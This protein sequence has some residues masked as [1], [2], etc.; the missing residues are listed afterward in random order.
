M[1]A[2]LP[3]IERR[4]SPLYGCSRSELLFFDALSGRGLDILV[5]S[6]ILVSIGLWCC[7]PVPLP[8]GGGAFYQ[9]DGF[10]TLAAYS[11]FADISPAIGLCIKVCDFFLCVTLSFV[12]F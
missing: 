11:N 6:A 10:C 1:L 4:R 5:R 7:Q 3:D 12:S 2:Y 8:P 9:L